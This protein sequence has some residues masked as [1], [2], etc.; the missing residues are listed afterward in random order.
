MVEPEIQ[1]PC[2]MCGGVTRESPGTSGLYLCPNCQTRTRVGVTDHALEERWAERT[3]R[4]VE[5]EE[6]RRAWSNGRTLL[7]DDR[8]W[9]QWEADA[10]DITDIYGHRFVCDEARYHRPTQTIIL[11]KDTGLV[12]VIDAPSARDNCRYTIVQTLIADDE[13]NERITAGCQ[14]LN[15][16]KDGFQLIVSREKDRRASK[17]RTKQDQQATA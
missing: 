1:V 6:V 8:D 9:S 4:P 13:S 16:S 3:N 12:T 7:E 15:V 10:V 2:H 5:K 14:E 17:Q 11:R